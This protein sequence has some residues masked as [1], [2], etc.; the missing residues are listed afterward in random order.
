MRSETCW[1][2]L[3]DARKH[4]PR[5]A[6]NDAGDLFDA[7]GPQLRD[8]AEAPQQLLRRARA[9]A[10]NIFKACLNRALRAA[11]AVKTDG[12]S[13]S[14]VADL[15]DQMKDRRMAFQAD[16]LILLP[17]DVDDFLLLGN[18]GDG[19]IDDFQ[20]FQRRRGR[21]ELAEAAVNENQAGE[22]LFFLLEPPVRRSMISR[23]LAK[24]SLPHSPRT[25][26][27]R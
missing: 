26:N 23:M 19:L 11:L 21:M 14:F 6:G 20:L 5:A 2:D 15:L 25:M 12:K 1:R 18:A 13:V 17:E 27:L 16:G 8:A 10:G 22:R 9:N 4:A 24:S 3:P 7:G